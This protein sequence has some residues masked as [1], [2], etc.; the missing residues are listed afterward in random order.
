[1]LS[2]LA[3]EAAAP[4]NPILPTLPETFWGAVCFAALYL[5]VKTVLLPPVKKVMTERAEQVRSNLDAADRARSA[6]GSAAGD[7]HDQL[8]DVRAEAAQI[9]DAA[10]A[11]AEAERSRIIGA[12]DAEVAALKAE[13]ETEIAAARANALSGVGPQVAELA[14]SAASQVMGRTVELSA[15]RPLV[16]RYLN[17]PN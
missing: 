12:A 15:A 2:I 11:E 7:V 1:V 4:D 16:E 14:T 8:A 9:I 17:N 5:L 6:A 3:A 13:V 10:R